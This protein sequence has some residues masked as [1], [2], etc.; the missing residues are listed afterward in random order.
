MCPEGA[1]QTAGSVGGMLVRGVVVRTWIRW[2]V[3]LLS[4]VEIPSSFSSNPACSP[5]MAWVMEIPGMP[6]MKNDTGS[7]G[8]KPLGVLEGVY[9]VCEMRLRGGAG[10][11]VS[12]ACN[13]E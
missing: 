2:I 12:F 5:P 1:Q 4:K 6:F 13:E 7:A 10:W 8:T 11:V 3:L 9:G